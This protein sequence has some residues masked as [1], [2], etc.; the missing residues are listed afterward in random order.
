MRNLKLEQGL[1]KMIENSNKPICLLD[2]DQ[3]DAFNYETAG[4]GKFNVYELKQM[5][6]KEILKIKEWK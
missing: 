1:Q 6:Q 4:D 2:V 5:L 3:S